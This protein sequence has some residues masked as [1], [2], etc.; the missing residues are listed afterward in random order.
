MDCQVVINDMAT[1]ESVIIMRL[2][3]GMIHGFL[4]SKESEQSLTL[5]KCRKWRKNGELGSKNKQE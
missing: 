3:N 2:E 1:L 4:G 5:I